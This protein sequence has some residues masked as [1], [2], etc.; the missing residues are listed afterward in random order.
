MNTIVGEVR[1]VAFAK[2]PYGFLACDGGL[3][4]VTLYPEL[5]AVLGVTYGGDGETTFAVPNMAGRMVIGSGS[6]SGFAV[7]TR[8]GAAAVTLT[9]DNLPSHAHTAAFELTQAAVMAAKI[10]VNDVAGTANLPTNS[11]LAPMIKTGVVQLS[12]TTSPV[13]DNY[14]AGV[15]ASGNASGTI[16]VTAN[17]GANPSPV[18]VLPPSCFIQY[19]IAFRGI[20]PTA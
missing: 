18:S 19:V 13:A 9:T 17:G 6:G 12:T 11:Y 14:L 1:M 16:T 5:F 20:V 4:S 3:Y 7:G 2:V 15:N 8:G 10:A